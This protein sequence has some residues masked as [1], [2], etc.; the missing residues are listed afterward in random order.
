MYVHMVY[1]QGM[2]VSICMH[3]CI[4]ILSFG[5]G[6]IKV[7]LGRPAYD[8][9]CLLGHIASTHLPMVRKCVHTYV[10]IHTCTYVYVCIKANSLHTFVH[11]YV[12]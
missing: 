2:S 4:W 9:V 11:M 7:E 1:V 12:R 6:S 8:S 3:L 10:Y 5:I